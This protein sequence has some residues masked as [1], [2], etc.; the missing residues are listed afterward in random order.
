[1]GDLSVF[2]IGGTDYLSTARDIMYRLTND[3]VDGKI[4]KVLGRQAQVVKRGIELQTGQFTNFSTPVR[5][6]NLDISAF[7]IDAI[8][9]KAKLL[10]GSFNISLEH[11]EAS[12]VA[13][14][15]KF[16]IVTAKDFT[17]RAEL[18]IPASAAATNPARVFGADAHSATVANSQMVFSMTING[19]AITLP[20]VVKSFE[21]RLND[22]DYQRVGVELVGQGP[23]SGSYPTAPAGSTSLL[24]KAFN[25]PGTALAGVLTPKAGAGEGNSYAGNLI[26]Q[27]VSFDFNDASL[28]V[29]S[30]SFVS[31]GTWTQTNA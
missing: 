3:T 12:G 9:Y 26:Y 2:T 19:V 18:L 24:E 13:D 17:A 31:Q 10:G 25:A 8:D 20:M 4:L 14:L 7:T 27:G 1:M 11:K 29:P 21:H 5:V 23:D 28:I 30:F 16:P 22:G 6:A 15:W